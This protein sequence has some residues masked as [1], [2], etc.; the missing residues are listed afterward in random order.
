MRKGP[1]PASSHK[2][3]PN[4]TGR[5]LKHGGKGTIYPDLTYQTMLKTDL[6][7]TSGYPQG[8]YNGR[9]SLGVE[10]WKILR[11]E[12][13]KEIW[14]VNSKRFISHQFSFEEG[15]EHGLLIGTAAGPRWLV[16]PEELFRFVDDD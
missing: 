7:G 16:G 11:K 13:V 1:I 8:T 3:R 6:V 4:G 15:E 9:L 2:G 5:A 14:I 10:E 12:G